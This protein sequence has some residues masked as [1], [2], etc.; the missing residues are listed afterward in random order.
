MPEK[1][2]ILGK[3]IYNEL[4]FQINR[5]READEGARL[6]YRYLDLR[7]PEVKNNIISAPTSSP[8]SAAA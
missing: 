7:N 1:V 4:P 8:R 3:C 5:S 6:K 2:E